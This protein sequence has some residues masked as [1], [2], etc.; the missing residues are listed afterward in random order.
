MKALLLA[1]GLGTRL[2]PFTLKVPK[3]LVPIA[4]K[5]LLEYHFDSLREAGFSDILINTHYLA[6]QVNA[7]IDAYKIRNPDLSIA[8]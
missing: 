8:I 2:R 6:D 4:G 5:P 1:A 3:C 7:F